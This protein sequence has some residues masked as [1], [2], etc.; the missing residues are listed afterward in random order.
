MNEF[1]K[2]LYELR[3]SKNLTQSELAKQIGV[4]NKTISKWE[5]GETYPE[6]TQLIALSNLFNISIDELLKG[7]INE[8][9]LNVNITKKENVEEKKVIKPSA[10]T[11]NI[12]LQI[13]IELTLIF[14]DIIILFSCMAFD[15]PYQIYVSIILG[16]FALSFCILFDMSITK[17]IIK[18]K[19]TYGKK[20]IHYISV[21]IFFTIASPIIIIC[22]HEFTSYGLYLPIFFSIIA[23]AVCFF[24]Y[25]EIMYDALEK[26]LGYKNSEHKSNIFDS[27]SG[28]ILL[29]ATI[30]YIL[31]GVFFKIW[32]P[33]WIIFPIAGIIITI[34]NFIKHSNKN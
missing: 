29:T 10:I 26:E 20:Y 24:I 27:I 5:N 18:R 33:S 12:A 2:L 9:S 4:S 13:I 28:I 1:A 11:R 34:V 21:G 7:K 16:S 22:L 31:F 17:D 32:H 19:F 6:T 15:V 14:A 30:V 3:K 8:L 25:G 23:M